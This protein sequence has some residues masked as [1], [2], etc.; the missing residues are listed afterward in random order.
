MQDEPINIRSIDDGDMKALAVDQSTPILAYF[1]CGHLREP[2]Y[3]ASRPFRDLAHHLAV[4]LPPCAERTAAF[5]KLLEAKDCAVRAA[6][7]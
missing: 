1:G 5:R 6:L 4:T 7:E 2:L 3:M